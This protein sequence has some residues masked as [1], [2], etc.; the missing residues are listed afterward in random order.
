MAYPGEAGNINIKET[1]NLGA[2]FS[3]LLL[4]NVSWYLYYPEE[5]QISVYPFLFSPRQD[6]DHCWGTFDCSWLH[7]YTHTR[8]RART[9]TH[10]CTHTHT[11]T[12][13]LM[14]KKYY[15]YMLNVQHQRQKLYTFAQGNLQYK[16]NI[17]TTVFFLIRDR[18]WVKIR[19]TIPICK[20]H[21]SFSFF[22][23]FFSF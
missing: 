4:L 22:H 16:E 5:K 23:L 9:A 8:A 10:T 18:L 2:Y 13:K 15:L 17:S 11:H 3:S 21:R 20:Y 12:K 7:A 19:F 14:L 1:R 6:H